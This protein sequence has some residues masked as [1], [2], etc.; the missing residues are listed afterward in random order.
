MP[1]VVT[2]GKKLALISVQRALLSPGGSVADPGGMRLWG[3]SGAQDSD[4]GG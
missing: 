4:I 3:K 1:V 2:F